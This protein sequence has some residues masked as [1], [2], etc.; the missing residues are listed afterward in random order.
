MTYVSPFS[1]PRSKPPVF[2]GG[3]FSYLWLSKIDLT[4]ILVLVG[5]VKKNPQMVHHPVIVLGIVLL[6]GY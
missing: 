2:A 3:Y 6:R 4:L 5:L 1:Y